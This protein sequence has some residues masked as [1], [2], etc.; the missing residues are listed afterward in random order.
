L[1]EH[2]PQGGDELNLVVEGRNYGWP[3]AILG[4]QYESHA[5]PGLQD[6]E[7]GVSFQAPA[8]AWTPSIAPSALLTVE[9]SEFPSWQ[10]ELLVAGLASRALHRIHLEADQPVLSEPIPV[11]S[12][13]RDM[14][15]DANGRLVLWTDEGDIVL[16]QS[17]PETEIRSSP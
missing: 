2:G 5:W 17:R 1:T 13:V 7:P 10:G 11:Y 9:G 6:A 14:V 8:F 3:F 16:I 12:R 15:L 4:T